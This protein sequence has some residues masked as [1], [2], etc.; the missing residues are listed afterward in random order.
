MADQL[1]NKERLMEEYVQLGPLSDPA[2]RRR[3]EEVNK[4]LQED[5]R[6]NPITR[7]SPSPLTCRVTRLRDGA[8]IVINQKDF[9]ETLH[10]RMNGPATTPDPS[11]PEAV[12]EPVLAADEG[13]AEE[14]DDLD[15]LDNEVLD[16][17]DKPPAKG[18][19]RKK[20]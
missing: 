13:E 3:L 16:E 14:D 1:S 8:S 18:R 11:P 5:A 20:S 2:S 15:D 9:N 10:A 19:G 17:L 12:P 6:V 4:L 7:Q